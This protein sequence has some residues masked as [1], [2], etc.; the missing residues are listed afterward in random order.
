[1]NR[2][3]IYSGK[4]CLIKIFPLGESITDEIPLWN[5]RLEECLLGESGLGQ[6][7]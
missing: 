2:N 3:K 4:K 7:N 6:M 1:M 5:I